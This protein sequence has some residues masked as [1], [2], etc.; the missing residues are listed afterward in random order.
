M[1]FAELFKEKTK[2]KYDSA[3]A[4]TELGDVMDK[5]ITI[6]KKR[7]AT[8]TELE[9]ARKH[10]EHEQAREIDGAI[11]ADIDGAVN[12][13]VSVQARLESMKE[14][15]KQAKAKAIGMIAASAGD[16]RKRLDDVLK[17]LVEVRNS[18]DTRRIKTIAGFAKKNGLKGV[19]AHESSWRLHSPAGNDH[20]RL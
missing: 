19:L 9:N 18:I 6:E 1:K 20:R 4:P 13:V 5:I 10:L 15:E 2:G 17:E 14:I 8:E 16:H 11:D 7:T 12:G 3:S